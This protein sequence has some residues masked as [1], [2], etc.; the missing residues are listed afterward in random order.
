MHSN[1][2]EIAPSLTLRVTTSTPINENKALTSFWSSVRRAGVLVIVGVTILMVAAPNF[3]W[4]A[5]S[6]S[7]PFGADFLQEWVGGRM[8]LEGHGDQLYQP[9]TFR[10]WQHNQQ[11]IGFSWELNN[12]FPPVY[13]P[14]HYG[15]FVALSWMPYRVAVLVW[16]TLLI[17]SLII[18]V[19]ALKRLQGQESQFSNSLFLP[20]VFLF[21]PVVLSLVLAQKSVMWLMIIAFVVVS[22]QRRKDFTAGLVFGLLSLKPTLFFLLP[23]VM[24]RQRRLNFVVGSTVSAAC[25]WGFAALLL[26]FEVWSGFLSNVS[27]TS[28]YAAQ[29]GYRLDWSCN[30]MS[31]AHALPAQWIEWGKFAI[32]LPLS[33]YTLF[34]V[35]EK[36]GKSPLSETI[37]STLT[38]TF[39]LSPHAYHYDLVIMLAPIAWIGTIAPRRAIVYYT[40]LAISIASTEF[41]LKLTGFSILPIVLVA[42]LCEGRLR[43]LFPMPTAERES[44]SHRLNVIGSATVSGPST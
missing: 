3:H 33:I 11:L 7:T 26:P 15:L 12:Y 42:F 22:L 28:N 30:W 13:P 38:A 34:C 16:V 14:P 44:P 2:A 5:D 41:F 8:I 43:N 1:V 6:G 27:S 25:L 9:S 20:A 35:F 29:N 18:S 21:P 32:C 10:E 40:I 37:F 39:L 31:I 24:L 23:L 17:T 36:D 4:A 19:H